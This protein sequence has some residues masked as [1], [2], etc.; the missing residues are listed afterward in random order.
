MYALSRPGWEIV[1]DVFDYIIVGA[2]SAGCVLANRLTADGRNTV[3]LV[4]AGPVDR[5]RNIH[6]PAGLFKLLDSGLT[7]DFQTVPQR[8][9]NDRRLPFVQARVLGGGSSINGQV[10]TRG[11][12]ED[13]DQWVTAFGAIGWGFEDL[14]PHFCRSERNDTLAGDFHGTDGPQG[15]STMSPDP[16]TNAFIQACQ[17]Y[18][19]PHT[20]DF[21]GLHQEGAGA[22][23]T[24][25]W[26]ARRCSAATGYLRPS[27]DRPNLTVRTGCAVT[28]VL[29][30]NDQA[31]GV[32]VASSGIE[33]IIHAHKEVIL[34][35]GAIGSP[36]LLMRSGIGSADHLREAGLKPIIDL[37]GVGE[38]LQDHLDI[39]VVLSIDRGH[40]LDKY[41]APHMMLW[42]GLQYVLFGSGPV[43][44]T[45]VEGGA[46]WS[47]DDTSGAADTQLH[48][49][50]ATGT[51]P[52]SPV[53]PTGAGCMLNGYFTRPESRG[54]VRLDTANPARPPCI[55]PNYLA[56]RKD[57]SMTVKAVRLMRDIA[58]QPALAKLGATEMLPGSDATS[59]DDILAFIRSH[60]R[61]SYHAAGTCRM[62]RD[63]NAVVDPEL[64]IRGIGGLRVCDASIMPQ[65]ISSNTNA[66]VIMIA[67]K[68][69]DLIM[70]H[71]GGPT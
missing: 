17:E 24:F 25:T 9:L 62:G 50:P 38:N 27:M 35:A 23:Q 1:R 21:N 6:R 64:R 68:A 46:F 61:T 13:Y 28:R 66:A 60:G 49:E 2:G 55:D 69:S 18:G 8:N 70:G 3:L 44:S 34:T 29:I 43:C 56:T 20:R 7:W 42:A 57:R 53:S 71:K 16:L 51:E 45:I 36:T 40:G 41:K 15:I 33:S 12:P 26:K 63:G 31:T 65:L 22:Y 10:F 54:S 32:A 59:D 11:R 58:R 4:E 14:L 37:P 19:I 39:D 52:G 5:N 30:E 67:E 48:F 47:T